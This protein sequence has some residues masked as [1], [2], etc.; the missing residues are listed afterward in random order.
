MPVEVTIALL[1]LNP[2]SWTYESAL[3]ASVS[4][5]GSTLLSLGCGG[6]SRHAT[7]PTPERSE[8]QLRSCFEK[9]RLLRLGGRGGLVERGDSKGVS[10]RGVARWSVR[11]MGIVVLKGLFVPDVSSFTMG[12]I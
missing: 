12:E 2:L 7:A 8:G 6:T 5:V 10:S 9:H 1:L 11:T 4:L 3:M